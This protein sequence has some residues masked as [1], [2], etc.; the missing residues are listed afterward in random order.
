MAMRAWLW[1]AAVSGLCA[2]VIAS[3]AGDPYNPSATGSST[4]TGGADAVSASSSSSSGAAGSGGMGG[5]TGGQGGGLGGAGGQGAGGEGGAG[6]GGNGGSAPACQINEECGKML[7]PICH[8]PV[9]AEGVCIAEPFTD[10]AVDYKP[11]AVGDCKKYVCDNGELTAV[12]NLNDIPK[13]PNV[14]APESCTGPLPA[15]TSCTLPDATSGKCAK[16]GEPR[17]V[18]CEPGI[19]TCGLGQCVSDR[20]IDFSCTNGGKNTGETDIDCGGACL[21]CDN[22][23]LCNVD[24]DCESHFCK[25]DGTGAKRCAEPTCADMRANGDETDIDCGSACNKPCSPGQRCAMAS[26][27]DSG[28]CYAGMCKPPNCS[29]NV[30]NGAEEGLDCGGECPY[31]CF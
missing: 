1:G 4:A 13:G 23:K 19:L 26:D 18:E 5:G 16:G 30:L 9:C 31:S 11:G 25:A 8:K 21:P 22:G 10:T 28:V 24:T 29:D 12:D 3:C 27:C 2:G 20:C 7:V 15:P 14:C 6:Q 17:C